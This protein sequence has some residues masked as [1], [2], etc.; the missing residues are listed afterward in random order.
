MADNPFDKLETDIIL[1][2]THH[3]LEK[4]MNQEIPLAKIADVLFGCAL[5][6]LQESGAEQKDVLILVNVHY[7]REKRKTS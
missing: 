1:R 5:A 7:Q 3:L 2:D 4:W 6:C